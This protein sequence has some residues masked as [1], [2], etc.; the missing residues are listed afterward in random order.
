MKYE[1]TKELD[2]K[3][4]W[5]LTGVKQATFNKMTEKESKK[6]ICTSFSNA[7]RH[8]FRLFKESRVAI[9]PNINVLA[10]SGYRGMQKIHANEYCHIEKRKRT[11]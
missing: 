8:D 3:K 5:W 1:E 2:N 11:L 10:D 6:I 4:F 9:L 7:K